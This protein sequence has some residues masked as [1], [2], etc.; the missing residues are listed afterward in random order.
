MS[1][2]DLFIKSDQPPIP[3]Y[4]LQQQDV[5]F[6][7]GIGLKRGDS[8][9]KT[10][11]N[12]VEGAYAS[13]IVD[14]GTDHWRDFSLT[15][16]FRDEAGQAHTSLVRAV[17][18]VAPDVL[19]IKSIMLD[20]QPETL[21]HTREIFSVLSFIGMQRRSI[22]YGSIPAAPQNIGYLTPLG[23]FIT[24]HNPQRSARWDI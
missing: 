12:P 22:N 18:S 1:L 21:R 17:R 5:Y 19:D 13:Y 14:N 11:G 16:A 10:V 24:R 6:L 3:P 7:L 20:G 9:A 23:R 15:L 8:E 2:K 4:R